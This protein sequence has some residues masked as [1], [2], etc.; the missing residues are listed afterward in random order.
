MG[1]ST[2]TSPMRSLFTVSIIRD[3]DPAKHASTFQKAVFEERIRFGDEPW[4]TVISRSTADRSEAKI[5]FI[6]AYERLSANQ[7][8]V[9]IDDEHPDTLVH[10]D[11]ERGR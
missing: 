6:D 7:C 4:L 5:F 2:K 11:H 3:E 1:E 10:V 8:P 9:E